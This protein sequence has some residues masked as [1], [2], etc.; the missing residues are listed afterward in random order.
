MVMRIEDIVWFLAPKE[1]E[2]L[3]QHNIPHL[4]KWIIGKIAFT[5]QEELPDRLRCFYTSQ[6]IPPY[7]K[8]DENPYFVE[9]SFKL[10][11]LY[12]QKLPETIQVP[13]K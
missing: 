7:A 11:Y 1:W 5:K 8:L 4:Q 12:P 13:P 9:F 10:T 3:T 2:R 6:W